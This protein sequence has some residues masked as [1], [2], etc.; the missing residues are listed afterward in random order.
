MANVRLI[1][2][3]ETVTFPDKTT[4]KVHED[5]PYNSNLNIGCEFVTVFRFIFGTFGI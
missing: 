3:P 4:D 1:F 5:L 2:R